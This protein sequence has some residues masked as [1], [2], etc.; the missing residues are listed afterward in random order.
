M[1]DRTVTLTIGQLAETIRTGITGAKT[2]E[3]KRASVQLADRVGAL[4]KKTHGAGKF[5]NEEWLDACGISDT[6]REEV[7]A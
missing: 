1:H 3:E 7:A 5:E 6:L 2:V 4:L